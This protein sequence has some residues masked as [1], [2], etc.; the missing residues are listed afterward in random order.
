M[1]IR[2][3]QIDLRPIGRF[4]RCC[5]G[6]GIVLGVY[7][8]YRLYLT[9]ELAASGRRAEAL[10]TYMDHR[11]R[12]TDEPID[13]WHKEGRYSNRAYR[14]VVFTDESGRRIVDQPCVSW[15]HIHRDGLIHPSVVPQAHTA[16]VVYNPADPTRW[17]FDDFWSLWGL[18]LLAVVDALG[19]LLFTAA[20]RAGWIRPLRVRLALRVGGASPQGVRG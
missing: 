1:N 19:I 18:P 14:T 10:V 7:G 5:I 12:S 13:P 4:G 16:T 8:C 3:F 17:A 15:H 11:L 2:Q 6:L 20:Y 9:S